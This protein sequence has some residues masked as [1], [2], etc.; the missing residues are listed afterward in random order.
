MTWPA[1]GPLSD[2]FLYITIWAATWEN[3]IFAYAKRKT[4]I[5]FAVT[6]KLISV[7]VF[8]TRIVQSLSYLNTKFQASSHF[9]RRRRLICVGPGRKPRRPVFWRRGSFNHFGSVKVLVN[10]EWLIML[11]YP[12][13]EDSLSTH[14]YMLKLG[15]TGVYI[16]FLL[17]FSKHR[18][19]VLVR[20]TS[21]LWL[22]LVSG[23]YVMS[24]TKKNVSIFIRK[25]SFLKP[26]KKKTIAVYSWACLWNVACLYFT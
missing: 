24:K 19:W 11:I 26:W 17:F 13:N 1:L 3:R 6:A 25:L 12:C 23:I 4:Q 5:S 10:W 16:V 18:L 2:R 22:W 9:L 21:L 7:F 20:T 14:F 15:F 8:A